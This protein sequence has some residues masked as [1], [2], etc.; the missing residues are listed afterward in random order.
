MKKDR[1]KL[2]LNR[3][4][5]RGLDAAHLGTLL[6]VRGGATNYT[7]A[8]LNYCCTTITAPIQ[9][10]SSYCRTVNGDCEC[11]TGVG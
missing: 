6:R 8:G 9:A 7:D 10:T 5:L 4:T 3:E 11:S 2:R 1:K